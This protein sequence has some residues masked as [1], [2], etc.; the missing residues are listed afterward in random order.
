M[1]K[2]ILLLSVSLFFTFVANAQNFKPVKIGFSL[3]YTVPSDGGGGILADFEPAYRINDQIAVGLRVEVATM[4]RNIVGVSQAN[5]SANGSYTINGIYY[6]M[7]SDFRPYVGLGLGLYS[8]ASFSL[9]SSTVTAAIG[10]SNEFGFYPRVGV[11]I[12]HFNFNLDYNII[13]STPA[14]VIISS[15]TSDVKIK[16]SF[17][18]IR[19]GFFLFGGK[20]K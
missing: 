15:N 7:N 16:N 19:V 2:L 17:L 4:I 13:P 6:L 12:G 11:D 3:G 14:Q 20:K 9:N 18:G 10:A 5:I 8:L 1:K